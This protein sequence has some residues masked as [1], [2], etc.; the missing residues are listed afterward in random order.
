MILELKVQNY[1]FI[2][3]LEINFKKGLNIIIGETGSGKSIILE[4]IQGLISSR[5]TTDL[6]KVGTKKSYLEGS[7]YTNKKIKQWLK[8]QELDE[9]DE[10]E[11]IS[12]SREISEKG[13]R[14]RING[15]LVPTKLIANLGELLL[16]IHSQSSEQK[17]LNPK[18]QIELLDD[19]IGSKHNELCQQ[20]KKDFLEWR[21]LV[22]KYEAE[23]SKINDKDKELD[24]LSFQIQE[25]NSLELNDPE[26]ENILKKQINNLSQLESSAKILEEINQSFFESENNVSFFLNSSVRKLSQSAKTDE[27]LI[28]YA[29]Q[30]NEI[31]EQ[32]NELIHEMNDLSNSSEEYIDIDSMNSRISQL[33]KIKRKHNVSTL[34]ELIDLQE[35]M[36]QR[37][38]YLKN[39]SEN[40]ESLETNCLKKQ[41]ELSVFSEKLSQAREEASKIL[42]KE[43][44]N[45]LPSL[46]LNGAKFEVSCQKTEKLTSDGSNKIEFFFQ[47]NAGDI[48][49]PLSKVASGGELSRITLILKSILGSDNSIIFDEIDSGTSGKVS[50]LIGERLFKLS[51]QC[52]VLCVTHQP[53][54][55]AFGDFHYLVNKIQSNNK[56]EL[57]V[58]ELGKDDE[59]I[60]ALM[61]LM[62]GERDKILAKQYAQELIEESKFKK[63]EIQKTREPQHIS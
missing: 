63:N 61:D 50:R 57:K 18:K 15:V 41:K 31:N 33:Q 23:K 30:L 6:I 37:I 17:I 49:R 43:V 51:T 8:E 11:I 36:N 47:A 29:E 46:G 25:L 52:Q 44:G 22:Q 54:V 28:P 10:S 40:L 34:K 39:L 21:K 9:N 48:L 58:D 14:G 60:E 45:Q 62:I 26:E 7:F 16:E 1:L 12:V 19:F 3:S 2:D 24:Y 5:L 42:S 32:L 27:R 56:T 38:D 59:K 53:L 13:S 4:A 55:A 20:Y 35:E